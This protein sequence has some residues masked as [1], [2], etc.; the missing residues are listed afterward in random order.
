MAAFELSITLAITKPM[1]KMQ[2]TP[3]RKATAT[4]KRFA[5]K[6]AEYLSLAIITSS[7]APITVISRLTT[8]WATIIC[9]GV[10]GVALNLFNIFFPGNWSATAAGT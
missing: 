2:S 3:S 4:F 6:A 9:A 7:M 8:I 1:E 5:G 10:V